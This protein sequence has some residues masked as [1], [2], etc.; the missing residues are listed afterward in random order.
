MIKIK[1]PVDKVTYNLPV[2]KILL[3]VE[4]E[5]TGKVE[6]KECEVT[7][8]PEFDPLT[9]I[10]D[11]ELDPKEWI[12]KVYTNG[13]LA[14]PS[15][16]KTDLEVEDKSGNIYQLRSCFPTNVFQN[17]VTVVFDHFIVEGRK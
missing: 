15:C 8:A 10:I 6:I 5:E 13:K 3:P 16:Y 12:G 17:E 1:T 2:R 4:D 7:G 14:H 9:L 11:D